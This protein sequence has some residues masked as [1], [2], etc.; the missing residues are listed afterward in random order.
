MRLA[1]EFLCVRRAAREMKKPIPP[2]LTALP[3]TVQYR[4]FPDRQTEE[5]GDLA[6]RSNDC[7]HRKLKI[8]ES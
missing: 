1:G 3:Y 6:Q 4:A 5:E 7:L 2:G 8:T